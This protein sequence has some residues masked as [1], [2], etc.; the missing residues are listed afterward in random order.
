MK[1]GERIRS[2]RVGA[3]MTQE[4]LAERLYVSRTLVAKWES[5]KRRPDRRTLERISETFG[6][7]PDSLA[8]PD[9]VIAG[10]LEKCLPA[11]FSDGRERVSASLNSFLTSLPEKERCVFL[12]RYHFLEDRREIA[13]RYGL[14]E[15]NVSVILFRVRKKL[16][17]HLEESK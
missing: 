1:I 7:P 4:E 17:K 6:A 3:G 16:K 9:P 11:G 13:E 8:S 5:G 10:E 2:L 15:G 14:T 12:R